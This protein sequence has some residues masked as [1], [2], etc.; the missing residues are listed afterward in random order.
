MIAAAIH[1]ARLAPLVEQTQHGAMAPSVISVAPFCRRKQW[2]TRHLPLFR[3]QRLERPQ[4][5]DDRIEIVWR[6][7]GVPVARHCAA[8]WRPVRTNARADGLLDVVVAPS[9]DAVLGLG[10]DVAA[11]GLRP[12]LPKSGD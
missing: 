6:D 9:A 11:D 3:F 8:Q 4:I 12:G 5:S 10:G 1:A 2:K 7:F